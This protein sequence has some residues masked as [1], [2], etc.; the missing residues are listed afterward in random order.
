[1]KRISFASDNYA[2]IHPQ[3]LT[4][5]IEANQHHLPAYGSDEITARAEQKFRN[6][7]DER[8]KIFFVLNGTGAN[9]TSLCAM[10]NN[11]QAIICADKA[12]IQVDECGAPEKFTGSKL[13]LVR[14][15]DGKIT[16]DKIAEHLLRVGDQHHV[17]P[18]VISISQTTEFGTIYSI[19]EIQAIADFAHQHNMLLH[20]DGARISNAV[21]SLNVDIK[22]MTQAAG[23]DVLSFGGTKNG[24]MIGEAVVFFNET[25]AKNFLYIRKQSMQLASKMRFIS[26]QFAALLTNGLWLENAKHANA[27]AALLAERLTKIKGIKLTHPVQA[28]AIFAIFPKEYISRLQEHYYFY[29]WNENLSQVRLMTSFDTTEAE[30]NDFVAAITDIA[31]TS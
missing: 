23:V 17:Q 25:L 16:I 29:T 28:N 1:M 11:F 21:A 6:L 8:T 9:V 13:L 12:H 30:I 5:I 3:I 18:R 27:M 14:T 22:A 24:M 10:N 20:M 7:F 19:N 31:A 4:A 26:A 2:G 15:D